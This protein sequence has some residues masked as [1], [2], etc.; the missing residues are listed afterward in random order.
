MRKIC[1]V[2]CSTV[3]N[4]WTS[5]EEH[6]KRLMR[7]DLFWLPKTT[8]SSSSAAHT[9][10]LKQWPHAPVGIRRSWVPDFLQI[11]KNGS[12][13]T[14]ESLK[15]LAFSGLPHQ[16]PSSQLS[17]EIVPLPCLEG[18]ADIVRHESRNLPPH[19]PLGDSDEAGIGVISVLSKGNE[20]AMPPLNQ[21]RK[22]KGSFLLLV[23]PKWRFPC[24]IYLSSRCSC[25][26]CC[27]CRAS[28]TLLLERASGYWS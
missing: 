12:C 22:N 24:Y 1:L 13:F 18:P 27:R 26:S 6:F 20:T 19:G 5:L 3:S 28:S 15:K 17:G 2:L 21:W 10:L 7:V 14:N 11:L 25:S 23:P 4:Q 9:V 16:M 8:R